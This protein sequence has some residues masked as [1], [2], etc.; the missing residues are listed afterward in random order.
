MYCTVYVNCSMYCT[1]YLKS[2]KCSLENNIVFKSNKMAKAV[3]LE[4]KILFFLYSIQTKIQKKESLLV[5][6]K[7]RRYFS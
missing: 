4:F 2:L 3:E 7:L 6:R 5:G 1:V